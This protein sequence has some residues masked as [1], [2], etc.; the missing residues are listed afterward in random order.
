MVVFEIRN[1]ERETGNQVI[2]GDLDLLQDRR[3]K[4]EVV[5]KL[6]S[7]TSS[8]LSICM[9]TSEF[10]RIVTPLFPVSPFI[11]GDEVNFYSFAPDCA[12]LIK[13]DVSVPSFRVE[14]EYL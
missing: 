2:K 11:Q 5:V 1:E 9:S 7:K 12:S 13:S 4:C 10:I 3:L 14:I 6:T 8:E